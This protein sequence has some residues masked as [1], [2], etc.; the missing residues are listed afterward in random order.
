MY[1]G[2]DAMVKR[3]G[4]NYNGHNVRSEGYCLVSGSYLQYSPHVS[5]W[6]C[7]SNKGANDLTTYSVFRNVQKYSNRSD[8]TS[9][10]CVGGTPAA[11]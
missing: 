4:E 8:W 7:S 3:F 9:L 5:T 1:V 2:V 10:S 6:Y 11:S